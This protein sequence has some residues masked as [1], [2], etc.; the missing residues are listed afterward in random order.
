MTPEQR[1][2]IQW[3]QSVG[4]RFTKKEAVDRFGNDYYRNGD[5]HVGDR[6]SRLVNCGLLE[7]EAPGKFRIGK[8]KKKNRSAIIDNQPELF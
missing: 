7:R 5:K 8:C 3:A 2:I 4:G 1:E 6:L